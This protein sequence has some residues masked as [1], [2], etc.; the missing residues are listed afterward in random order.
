MTVRLPI[1]LMFAAVIAAVCV[2]SL[3]FAGPTVAANALNGAPASATALNGA[4]ASRG[5]QNVGA[6]GTISVTPSSTSTTTAIA[7]A[8]ASGTATATASITP[9]PTSTSTPTATA[10]LEPRAL[11]A[12]SVIDGAPKQ[13]P[14]AAGLEDVVSKQCEYGKISIE[15]SSPNR[16]GNRIGDVIPITVRIVADPAV[17]IDFTSLSQGVLKFQERS[18]VKLALEQPFTVKTDSS[19]ASGKTTYL[20]ELR[21]Q[22]FLPTAVNFSLD[23]RYQV[24][25]VAERKVLTSP[26]LPLSNSLTSDG[27]TSLLEGDLTDV[28]VRE[29]WPIMP[30]RV[31]ALILLTSPLSYELWKWYRRARPGYVPTALETAWKV[32]TPIFAA[33]KDGF[34][35]E[36][37][38]RIEDAVR[39]YLASDYT[40]IH[41]LTRQEILDLMDGDSRSESVGKI[42]QICDQILYAKQDGGTAEALGVVQSRELMRLVKL[43]IPEER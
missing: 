33:S 16:F 9:T 14:V 19:G 1:K 29:P 37:I 7:S 11:N 8:T 21:V 13:T 34:R 5:L 10:T 39:A 22:N 28:P 26:N 25:G 20:I 38:S 2:L 12:C 3:S 31:V 15:V 43:V 18:Q 24:Q 35:I 4:P 30:L 41:S 42:L 36:Q 23:L 40:Q 6:A 27:G 17:S 32:L